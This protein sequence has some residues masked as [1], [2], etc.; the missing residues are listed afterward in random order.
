M[1]EVAL[2]ILLAL[3]G[4]HGSCSAISGEGGG[5]ISPSWIGAIASGA[6]AAGC[7]DF[8][9]SMQDIWLSTDLSLTDGDPISSWAATAGSVHGNPIEGT[10]TTRCEYD[11]DT[12][13][14]GPTSAVLCDGIDDVMGTDSAEAADYAFLSDNG[15]AE[16]T[17]MVIARSMTTNPN[18]QYM[19]AGNRDVS[20]GGTYGANL[21][22]DD[23]S[24]QSHDEA[25]G[26]FHKVYSSGENAFSADNAVDISA[27]N[28]VSLR[29][30]QGAAGS[31]YVAYAN[32]SSVAN[33]D[34]GTAADGTDP[35]F[36]ITIGA[37]PTD[38]LWFAHV[39]LAMVGTFNASLSGAE[40]AQAE[41]AALCRLGMS[42]LPV[43]P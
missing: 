41:S 23:R 39:Q 20:G 30:T 21:I 38:G 34:P 35:S 12:G 4:C 43:G 9:S 42:S 6:T 1:R 13:T 18:T 31:D 37:T 32:G 7:P 14:G 40:E 8:P 19:L 24:A 3:G 10:G 15:G 29:Y 22:Y 28:L 2:A 36:G 26:I 17:L 16:G 11:T 27:W 33:D 25:V 5:A